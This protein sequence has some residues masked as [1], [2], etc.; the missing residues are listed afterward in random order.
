MAGG[1]FLRMPMEGSTI[2]QEDFV[3]D[4]IRV[5]WRVW[6]VTEYKP[7]NKISPDDEDKDFIQMILPEDY[8]PGQY[9]RLKRGREKT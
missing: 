8:R 3:L 2:D 9:K 5:S 6:Y 7:A 1:T 4:A